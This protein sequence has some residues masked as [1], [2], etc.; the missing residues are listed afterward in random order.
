MSPAFILGS[1]SALLAALIAIAIA[2]R[3]KSS[4]PPWCFAAG[5]AILGF[6]AFCAALAADALLPETVAYWESIGF[7]AGAFLPAIWILFSITYSRGHYRQFVTKWRFI[8]LGFF[9]VPVLLASVFRSQ[10]VYA[11][12]GTGG[13]WLLRLALPAL[14]M[15]LIFLLS[16]ILVL[17]NL[18]ATFRATVGTM[19]W[20][21]KF[22]VL[23]LGVLFAVRAYTSTQLLLFRSV[24]L[25]MHELNSGALL[26][27]CLLMLR[28]LF[29]PGHF[30][31]TVF[32]SKSV[33]SSSLTLVL[34]GVY[35]IVVGVLAKLVAFL[36]GAAS[37][38]RKAFLVLAVIVLLTVVL[39]SDRV[40]LYSKRFL[41]RYF[42]R[43]LY[44]YRTV[45]R[46]FTQVTARRVE[47]SDLCDQLVKLISDVFQALSV[48]IWLVDERKERLVFAASTFLSIA[49]AG[50][51]TLEP[52]DAA[53]VISALT[54]H[55]EPIDLDSSN[56]IW[57]SAL[58]RSH[59]EEFR[60]GGNRVCVP[61]IASGELLGILVLGDRVGGVAFSIQD[62]DLLRS[63]SDQAAA[64]LLNIQL[65]HRLSQA[66]QLE[67]FQ[68]M[69]AFFVHDL[70][71]TAS[72]LSLMLQNLP[73]HY[74]DPKFREDALRGISKTV[75]HINDLISRLTVLRHDLEVKAAECDLNDLITE[76][77]KGQDKVPGVELVKGLQQIPKVRVDP[78]QIQ[79]VVTNLLLNA[80][81]ALPAGGQIR[82][83]TGQ[84]N[85][86]VVMTVA[87]NGCGMTPDFLN[88][89]LF[90]PFSTTKKKGIGIGMFHC[91]MIVEA[92]HGRIEVESEVGKGTS[93]RVLLPLASASQG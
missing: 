68:A 43:P 88:R 48:S 18:E 35:L 60:K 55:P 91:K 73:V 62:F 19:R 41:S 42:Q 81:E 4:L 6:E 66:K 27:G 67:A 26:L 38:E 40:R 57:A 61:M 83:E 29:R 54:Q 10:L 22:M 51:L 11:E 24:H 17:M 84:K 49:K 45:W 53:E 28:S 16:S 31:V 39:L 71:N 59:P 92:H 87:D 14:G 20:R 52:A 64:N 47:Q 8:L 86:W 21:I 82:I 65:S 74:Q 76:T 58:R 56:E 30:D 78:S 36:G 23:G 25:T 85:G 13:Q 44:D 75:E 12:V 63:A 80:R 9:L 50:D 69:S 46:T 93:F 79:K 5:L 1:S 89:S 34:S 72:T 37:F 70:K 2:I 90:R 3:A 15:N 32:P 7:C 77:L 33:L